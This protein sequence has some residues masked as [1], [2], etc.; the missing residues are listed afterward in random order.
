MEHFLLLVSIPVVMV[1]MTMAIIVMEFL[2]LAKAV[3]QF[4][5]LILML[6]LLLVWHGLSYC[7]CLAFLFALSPFFTLIL[8]N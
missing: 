5:L 1:V 8:P 4:L 7:K 2:V 3:Y 6:Y